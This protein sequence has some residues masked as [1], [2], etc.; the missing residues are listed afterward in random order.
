MQITLHHFAA[1]VLVVG[2][3]LG[4]TALAL[5]P[6]HAQSASG[7]I[8]APATATGP[9]TLHASSDEGLY[10]PVADPKALVILGK[11]RFTVLTPEMIRIEWAAD[12]KFEDHAS[13]VFLNRRL[14]VPRYSKDLAANGHRLTIKTDALTLTY[15]GTGADHSRMTIFPCHLWWMASRLRG[16]PGR[17]ICR[18]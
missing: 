7:I 16:V 5:A 10:N 12:G 8:K 2:G 18:T 6:A 14:P 13:L 9:S 15:L 3:I 17:S 1:A 4:A 11:T